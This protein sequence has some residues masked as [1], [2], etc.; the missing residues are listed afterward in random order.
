VKEFHVSWAILE[1]RPAARPSPRALFVPR[2]ADAEW[3]GAGGELAPVHVAS[4]V[5]DVPPVVDAECPG[6]PIFGSPK[7]PVTWPQGRDSAL[8]PGEY[9]GV[10]PQVLGR[11]GSTR[12]RRNSAW[13]LSAWSVA[14]TLERGWFRGLLRAPV[15]ERRGVDVPRARRAAHRG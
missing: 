8:D 11:A 14:G 13:P 4:D 6:E 10:D 2:A 3:L 5:P 1:K 9:P 12:I 15:V 7:R